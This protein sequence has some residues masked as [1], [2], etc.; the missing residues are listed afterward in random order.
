MVKNA[1]HLETI[2]IDG[3]ISYLLLSTLSVNII[4]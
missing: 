3:T 4:N 1:R 2:N